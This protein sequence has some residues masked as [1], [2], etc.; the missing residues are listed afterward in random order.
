MLDPIIA[1]F[2]GLL[3]MLCYL[4]YARK[5]NIPKRRVLHISVFI[6]YM[7]AV[8][9]LTLF[10]LVFDRAYCQPSDCIE[11]RIQ[12]IP[13]Y[14]IS[15]M[16][17]YGLPIY[18]VIQIGGNLIMTI[19]FGIVLP[20]LT[21]GVVNKRRQFLSVFAIVL[22]IKIEVTQLMIGVLF[23]TFYRTMDIDDIILNTAGVFIGYGLY[24]IIK[25]SLKK[26]SETKKD[27]PPV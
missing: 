13:F 6:L 10:P 18:S 15:N 20:V 8:V 7:C 16:I 27:S 14:T 11:N 12:P 4:I 5:N 26:H 1:Y 3:L 23:G 25:K 22:P 2:A 21:S 19:P 17:R 9:A 24:R